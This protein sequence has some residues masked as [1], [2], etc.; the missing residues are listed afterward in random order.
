MHSVQASLRRE[1][2]ENEAKECRQ[3]QRVELQYGELSSVL[4]V[5]T[6][7]MFAAVIGEW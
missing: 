7:A 2:Y 5:A 4:I 1:V 3:G 6:Q